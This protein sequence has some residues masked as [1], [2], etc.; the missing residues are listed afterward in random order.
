MLLVDDHNVVRQGLWTMLNLY[1]DI[2]VV[3]EAAD[4]VEAVEKARQL[5]P[6]VI[7]MD[8]SMP[9]MDGLEA[10]RI[11]HSQF[12]DIR[13]IGLSMHD[14]DEQAAEMFK[15]G[16]IAYCTKENSNDMLLYAIRE[17]T[18]GASNFS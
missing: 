12:P 16:A 3:G 18:P 5:Q 17:T 8:I 2:E 9:K 15:A 7:L 4:G 13:I 10:T 1:S 6:D 11:I 14:K